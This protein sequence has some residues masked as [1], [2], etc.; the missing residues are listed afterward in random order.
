MTVTEHHEL[1][2]IR[3]AGL[4][5]GSITLTEFAMISRYHGHPACRGGDDSP[6]G[7]GPRKAGIPARI[8]ASLAVMEWAA[9]PLRSVANAQR[10]PRSG[11]KQEAPAG[12][13][14]AP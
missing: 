13:V 1:N 7:Q 12:D 8:G 3:D 9:A 5:L 2:P 14:H 10:T 6:P 4:D 11:A